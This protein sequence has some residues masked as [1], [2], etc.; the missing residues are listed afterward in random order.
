MTARMVA[1]LP[2][3]RNIWIS[4]MLPLSSVITSTTMRAT[5]DW[6]ARADARSRDDTSST[7]KPLRASSVRHACVTVLSA[8]TM[9][10]GSEVPG[11]STGLRV[12]L[13]PARGGRAPAS[14]V[15]RLVSMQ[16]HYGRAS[17]D[18]SRGAIIPH[19]RHATATWFSQFAG[20]GWHRQQ[21]LFRWRKGRSGRPVQRAGA[22]RQGRGARRYGPGETSSGRQRSIYPAV[23]TVIR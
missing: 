15:R 20:L 19:V 13:E 8:A 2:A 3:S 11:R 9:S 4:S 18:E 17:L 5:P 6:L 21:V 16:A 22:G 14:G 1:G 23:R 7:A 10:T 12:T